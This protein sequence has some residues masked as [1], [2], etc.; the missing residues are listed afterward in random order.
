MRVALAALVKPFL[1][2][3]LDFPEAS[4]EAERTSINLRYLDGYYSCCL[5]CNSVLK[6]SNNPFVDLFAVR[7][8][9]L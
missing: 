5:D 4:L 1:I 6:P 2:L 8:H 9:D 7:T 3:L